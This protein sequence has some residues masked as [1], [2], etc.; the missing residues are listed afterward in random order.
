M[1]FA[2]SQFWP[3]RQLVLCLSQVG[4]LWKENAGATATEY[5]FLIAFIAIVAGAG[6]TALGTNLS[7][8]MTTSAQRYRRWF[9]R[10]PIQLRITAVEI[11]ISARIKIPNFWR[12]PQHT[13][14]F[15]NWLSMSAFG[16]WPQPVAATQALNLSAGVSNPSVL[17]GRSLS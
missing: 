12:G 5:A 3:P 9:A 17:R 11:V 14:R 4:K 13:F 8:F 7:A 15:I 10:C 1:Y 6:M 2:R 16:G